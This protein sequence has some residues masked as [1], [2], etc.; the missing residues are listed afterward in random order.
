[1]PTR[2]GGPVESAHQSKSAAIRS[3]LNHPVID[4]DGHTLEM[5]PVFLDY[6]RSVAGAG[7]ADRFAGSQSEAMMN[8]NWLGL[9]PAERRERALMRP[10]W[11][12]SP[13]RNT[14]DLA[15]AMIPRLMRE[16]LDEMGLDVSV[17]YPTMGLLTINLADDELRCAATRALNVM[18]SE[19]FAGFTDRLIPVATIPMHTPAEAIAELEHSVRHLGLRAIMMASYVRRPIAAAVKISPEAA[20][21]TYWMDTF[22]LDS[23]YDYDPVWAKCQEL[24]V[25][26]T[27]HSIG[28]GWGSR[29]SHSSYLH[30][31]LGNFASSADAVCRGLFLGGVPVRFPAL[32]FAFMEGGVAWARNLYCELISHWEKRN[33]EAMENYNPAHIDRALFRELSARFGGS[34]IAGREDEIIAAYSRTSSRGADPT[35]IDEWAAS[36][37]RSPEDIYELFT[38]RF[39]FGCEGDDPLNALAFDTKGSPFGARLHAFYGSDIGHWDVP[40]MRE[41]AEEAW[42]LVEDGIISEQDLCDFVFVNPARLWTAVNPD[43]FKGTVVESEVAKLL[44]G[45]G[46]VQA[47]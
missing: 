22:G 8:M 33:R 19:M 24:R 38:G 4:G 1:M 13:A 21:W 45:S 43:F 46:A 26:P 39:Y 27:F 29:A 5:Y 6:L 14:L 9:S 40:D 34:L 36:G 37:V 30:N 16:R 20:R 42:E 41:A 10:T 3:R 18:K 11:W 23:E 35:M 31:H 2:Q 28:Y 12:P 44:A 7:V 47:H 17:V 32:R 15:T 25:A